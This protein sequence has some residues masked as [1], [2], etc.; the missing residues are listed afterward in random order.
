MTIL[1]SFRQGTGKFINEI[2]NKSLKSRK[3]LSWRHRLLY[4]EGARDGILVNGKVMV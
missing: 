1:S 3:T 2:D 4:G